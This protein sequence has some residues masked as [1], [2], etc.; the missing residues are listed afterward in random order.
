MYHTCII[1]VSCNIYRLA[2]AL[3]AHG[4][5]PP[6]GVRGGAG[7]ES[8]RTGGAQDLSK[9]LQWK[10]G[11]VICM[12]LYTSLLDNTTPIHCSPLSTAPRC[13]EYPAAQEPAQEPVPL[14]LASGPPDSGLWEH[15]QL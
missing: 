6:P 12:L 11:V 7:S 10:Q 9:G 1:Y 8:A 13:N 14:P 3:R 15:K 5:G 2:S 4:E